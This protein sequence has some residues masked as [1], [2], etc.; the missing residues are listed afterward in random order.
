VRRALAAA[1]QAGASDPLGV[2]RRALGERV[3]AGATSR[4]AVPPLTPIA[5]EPY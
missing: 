2:F 1:R 3:G 4:E 5:D